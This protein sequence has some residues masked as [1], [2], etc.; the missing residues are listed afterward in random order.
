MKSTYK[1][2]NIYLDG[3]PLPVQAPKIFDAA[4]VSECCE[5]EEEMNIFDFPVCRRRISGMK[6]L[7]Y[8]S[9]ANIIN[10]IDMLPDCKELVI[11]LDYNSTAQAA[12]TLFLKRVLQT[13]LLIM[14]K[15]PDMSIIFV[16]E[17]TDRRNL[18]HLYQT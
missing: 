3:Q 5:L 14:K 9:E 4:D 18:K 15:Y 17:G 11:M 1:L 8:Q 12:N 2:L 6:L 13:A 16:V 7:S 10:L